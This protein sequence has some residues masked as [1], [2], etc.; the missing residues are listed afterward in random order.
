MAAS[1]P[2]AD[3]GM[4]RF[5]SV[6][7]VWI[8]VIAL[9]ACAFV[10]QLPVSAASAAGT[11]SISGN[12]MGAPSTA[13]ESVSVFLYD[14]AGSQI[15]SALTDASGNYTLTGLDAGSYT[16]SFTA[17]TYDNF[18]AEWWNGKPSRALAD[19]FTIAA[20]QSISS[21]N[22]VLAVGATISGTTQGAGNVY[23]QTV[24]DAYLSSDLTNI[25][26]DVA[27]DTSGNYTVTGLRAGTYVLHIRSFFTSNFV[28]EW[29]N[30]QASG[31]TATP[32]TVATQ[33]AVT[34]K[35]AVLA[36]GATISGNVKGAPSTNL[37]GVSVEAIDPSTGY[38]VGNAST[39]AAGNYTIVGLP[40]GTYTLTFDGAGQ[41]FVRQWWND[42]PTGAAADS[43]AIAA[44]GSVTGKDAVLTV[45]ATISGNV[46]GS[47]ST[48]LAGAEVDLYDTSNIYGYYQGTYTDSNGN[49]SF[50]S[51]PAGSYKLKFRPASG[52]NFLA[53]WWNNPSS[54]SSADTFSLAAGES[55][56]GKDAVLAVPATISGN[57]KGAPSTNLAG[58]HVSAYTPTGGGGSALTDSSGDYTIT[59]LS[60][61]SYTLN[62]WTDSTQNYLSQSWNGKPDGAIPD[63]FT[64]LA[65][66]SVTGKDAILA[67]GASISGHV[68]GPGNVNVD[69][70][71]VTAVDSAGNWV[72]DGI[73]NANGNYVVTQLPASQYTLYFQPAYS[74]GWSTL[75]NEWWGTKNSYASATFITVGSAETVTGEDMALVTGATVSGTVRDAAGAPIVVTNTPS[76]FMSP[77]VSVYDATAASVSPDSLV[78]TS[79]S[80]KFTSGGFSVP[81]LGIGT[82]KVQFAMSATG[83][84]L[85][86]DPSAAFVPQWYNLAY[87]VGSAAVLTVTAGGQTLTGIDGV[88]NNPTF[89]DVDPTSPFYTYVQWM[90]SSGI[91]TGT[92]QPSGKPLY[93]PVDAVSRQAMALFLY[94]L[95]AETF[96]PPATQTF[97]DVPPASPFFTAVEWMANRG[98]STGTVQPSGKP[99]Y[100][101]VDPVSR[102]A[103]A[104]FLAR[105]DHIDVSTPPATQSFSDVATSL[106][107]FAAAIGWMKSTGISTGTAQ[108]SGLPLYKPVDPVSRQAMAAFLYRLA[109]LPA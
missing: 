18:I 40:A 56:T 9:I 76:L 20:G 80:S 4:L 42:K 8:M 93:K 81:G 29:W 37:V 35:D 7:L 96:V 83:Y 5:R 107:S 41:N 11:A 79:D 74:S 55:T 3:A 22:V 51:L 10:A 1:T 82:Y 61:G 94:R 34:G 6:R 103:M 105:Y 87:S 15:A 91:S 67:V 44:G 92:V 54:S 71:D 78:A 90:S 89:A 85:A 58:A 99:L 95:S 77:T 84:G 17:Q 65:G 98:I 2:P 102:Q 66:A 104:L 72:A 49:Y 75:A 36:V 97:A 46:K 30:H 32:I 52:Q 31:S 64:V 26:S 47:P 57:V 106:P 38:G 50:N 108:P 33:Q 12:V 73:T 19:Y 16:L 14:G 48:N 60:A 53:Q 59:G 101:P 39:D 62:F 13:L 28:A 68:T 21:M 43:F 100:K 109:H 63:S 70:I 23:L 88:L 24:V 86:P 25:V 27:S 69:G 45:G